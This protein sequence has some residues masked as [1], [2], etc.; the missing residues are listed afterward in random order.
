M[1]ESKK[2]IQKGTGRTAGR[3]NCSFCGRFYAQREGDDELPVSPPL[4]I[5]QAE[6]GLAAEVTPPLAAGY[7]AAISNAA[8]TFGGD[9]GRL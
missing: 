2:T 5:K 4:I 9:I 6:P 7:S 1:S 8:R 3:V